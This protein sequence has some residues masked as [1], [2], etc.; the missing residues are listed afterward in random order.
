MLVQLAQLRKRHDLKPAGISQDRAFPAAKF[1]QAAKPGH[2]L[3]TGAQ[4]QVIG[5]AKND[6]GAKLFHLVHIHRL[7]GASRADRHEG[8]RAHHA[9]R[10]GNLTL[11]SRA[12]T[13]ENLESEI[14]CGHAECLS[15][16][17]R[18]SKLASP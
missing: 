4:H 9:A 11:T 8:G 2:A 1:V 7:H 13:R 14:F 6:I 10:H 5:I 18:S 17:I 15:W 12:I 3:G 16:S